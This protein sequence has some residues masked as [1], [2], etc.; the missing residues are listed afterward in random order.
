MS[1]ADASP[2]PSRPPAPRSAPVRILHAPADVG[3]HA[4]GLAQA[5]R[6]LGLHSD[7]AVFAAS[8]YGYASD[9]EFDL[10]DRG[11]WRRLGTRAA[12][13]ARALRD[14]D[15]IH[16]NFGQSLITLRAAGRVLNE[17]P[18][19]KR[20]GITVLVTFQGCDVRPQAHCFCT[21][22]HCSAEDRYR[23]PNAARFLRYA[24]RCFHLNPDLRRWL[25]GSR[26][27][28][29]ASVDLAAVRSVAELPP[30]DVVRVAHAPSNREVKG[31]AHVVTAVEQLRAEGVAVVLDLIEGVSR[32][33]VLARVA[34][35]DVVVDQLLIG[36]YGGFAVEAMALRK[37]VVCH[38]RE[39]TPEDNP[40]GDELPIVHATPATLVER[41]RELA[42]DRDLRLRLGAE[43]R[44][45]CERRHDPRVVAR[46][47]LEGVVALPEVAAA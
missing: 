35:A 27:V 2:R 28:P 43:G 1:V 34:A 38:I 47:V 21:Q 11:P 32:E 20:A 45:F 5:E 19:L 16:F 29:Y 9:I 13:T 18:L 30:A 37:P 3:G 4:A 10:H 7:V 42:R 39:Q 14:Y 46:Q 6:E 41:L 17:L 40:F 36:W 25:P 33:E 22:E 15:V 44:Q 12:F 8:Q 24:D 31:T 23:A 26:F